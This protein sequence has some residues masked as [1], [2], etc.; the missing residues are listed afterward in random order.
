LE[1]K[2]RGGYQFLAFGFSIFVYFLCRDFQS[3]Q[4]FYDF[5]NDDIAAF[6][7]YPLLFVSLALVLYC[8]TKYYNII[9]QNQFNKMMSLINILEKEKKYVFLTGGRGYIFKIS[10]KE[11]QRTRGYYHFDLLDDGTVAYRISSCCDYKK[12]L[13]VKKKIRELGVQGFLDEVAA[14]VEETKNRK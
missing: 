2:N 12:Y 14:A 11:P 8:Y 6:I 7:K 3:T 4:F 9:A 10:A 1:I 5:L 13:G